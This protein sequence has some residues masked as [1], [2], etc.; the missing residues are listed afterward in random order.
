VTPSDQEHQE[1]KRRSRGMSGDSQRKTK[2]CTNLSFL[3]ACLV[4][5]SVITDLNDIQLHDPPN[6]SNGNVRI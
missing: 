4:R 3:N 5:L 1:K 6:I 2:V